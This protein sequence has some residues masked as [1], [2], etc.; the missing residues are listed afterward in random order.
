[1]YFPIIF[2]LLAITILTDKVLSQDSLYLVGTITNESVAKRIT[3]VKG[4][5]D[6]NGDGYDDFMV[7]TFNNEVKLYLGSSTFNLTPSIIF[8]YPGKDSLHTS[9]NCAGIGDVNG[10]GYNDFLIRGH[11]G[12]WGFPEGKVFLYYGGSTIDTIPKYEFY[13]RWIQDWFGLFME[14][15]GDTNKDGFDPTHSR[16][17]VR[18]RNTQ[19]CSGITK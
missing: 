11:F 17:Q 19:L 8:H 18:V 9:E 1:M 12:D 7:T 13:E 5:G 2:L 6:V 4:I 16:M 3:E 14:G 10:D 15:V